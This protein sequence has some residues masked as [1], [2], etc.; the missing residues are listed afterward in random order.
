M[1]RQWRH[2]TGQVLL[3][4]PAGTLEPDEAPDATAR[5]ELEEEVGVKAAEWV[6]G[7]QFYTAPGF[8]TELMHTF[9]ATEI[10]PAQAGGDEDEQIEVDWV[11]LADA[12]RAIDAGRIVDAKSIATILWLARRLRTG[13][14]DDPRAR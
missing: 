5:R 9:I 14:A 4:V 12:E 1:V 2:A 6:S 11:S 10:S 3:E 13:A 7:P 8:C